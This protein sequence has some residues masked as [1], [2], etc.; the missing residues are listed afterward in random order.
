MGCVDFE[1]CCFLLRL[2]PKKVSSLKT[3]S[4]SDSTQW[5]PRGDKP[6]VLHMSPAMLNEG[7]L[8]ENLPEGVQPNLVKVMKNRDSLVG[9]KIF[10]R[11]HYCTLNAPFGPRNKAM[12]KKYWEERAMLVRIEGQPTWPVGLTIDPVT[13]VIDWNGPGGMYQWWPP[14]GEDVPA[15]DHTYSHIIFRNTRWEIVGRLKQLFDGRCI[16]QNNWCHMSAHA[17]NP[18]LPSIN[19]PVKDVLKESWHLLCN[20]VLQRI[21]D[22]Q[23]TLDFEVAAQPPVKTSMLALENWDTC[24]QPLRRDA[25]QASQVMIAASAFEAP[26]VARRSSGPSSSSDAAAP[27]AETAK[28]EKTEGATSTP[29]KKNPTPE[30][31]DSAVKRRQPAKG[32]YVPSMK[33]PGPPSGKNQ[34]RS[35]AQ[36]DAKDEF[37]KTPTHKR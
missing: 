1:Y 20:S 35:K 32:H 33:R 3:I 31:P 12:H 24:Q 16:F 29:Q 27:V 25:C 18:E 19:V 36:H 30:I 14:R 13:G 15:E 2:I 26:Q 17:F 7:W 10:Q 5:N 21:E 22:E 37:R 11:I 34:K 8:K 9:R 6:T 4:G 23:C 28:D